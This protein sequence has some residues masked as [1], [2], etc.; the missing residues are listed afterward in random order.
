MEDKN[1][2]VEIDSEMYERL[3]IIGMKLGRD[4]VTD[5]INDVIYYQ[6]RE[7]QEEQS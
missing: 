6:L 1:N 7:E 4:N 5:F 3:A 2:Q